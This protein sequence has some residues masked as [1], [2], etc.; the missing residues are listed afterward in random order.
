MYKLFLN[1]FFHCIF[2]ASICGN[3]HIIPNYLTEI[4]LTQFHS[5]IKS[6]D[7]IYVI[8]LDERYNRWERTQAICKNNG[9][10][11]NR[12][13]AINGWKLSK[14]DIQELT[15]S[16]P[17]ITKGAIG[18][19]LSHLS[20]LRHALKNEFTAIWVMEDDIT[21][22][23]NPHQIRLL[24]KE[25]SLIDPQWDI[26]Y[27]DTRNHWNYIIKPIKQKNYITDRLLRVGR[28]YGTHSIIISK[29]GMEKIF[30]YFSE[31]KLS[32]PIDIDIHS[33]TGIRKYSPTW[34]ITSV[35]ESSISDTEIPVN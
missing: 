9:L 31:K 21:F 19:L 25:L 7:C 16:R 27:T 34:D 30:K 1:I 8:N 18:C 15:T 29:N 32:T 12:V 20:I 17:Q 5:G 13:S 3:T 28:R 10:F 24:I 23:N 14:R 6:I 2:I 22:V 11:V 26:F 4:E 33:I 35:V